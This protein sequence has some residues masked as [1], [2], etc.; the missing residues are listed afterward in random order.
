MADHVDDDPQPSTSRARNTIEEKRRMRNMRKSRK[1]SRRVDDVKVE[2]EEIAQKRLVLAKE[3]C[4]AEKKLRVAAEAEVRKFRGMAKTYFDRFCWEVEQRRAAMVTGSSHHP[5]I[6]GSGGVKYGF[7]EI[8]MNNLEDPV[9]DGQQKSLYVGRGSFAIVRVQ[10]YRG[11]KVAVKEYLPRCVKDDLLHEAAVLS[12]LCHPYLPLLIGV[13][14]SGQPLCLVM[15]FHGVDSFKT[16]I[17]GD[18][19]RQH[20]HICA[21]SGWLIL[22]GQLMEALRYLHDEAGYL[23]ND[24]KVDNILLTS[25]RMDGMLPCSSSNVCLSDEFPY[26][27]ILIDFGK[28]STIKERKYL[29]LTV[30]QQHMYKIKYTHIAGEVIEGVMPRSTKSDMYALGKVLQ[31]VKDERR[32]YNLTDD[33]QEELSAIIDNCILPDYKKRPE[34]GQCLSQIKELM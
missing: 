25:V 33:V 19:L 4:D 16:L 32:Y 22:T 24:I 23:H 5:K 1:R 34:A 6:T 12:Q 7:H 10:L 29:Q 8:S 27:V 18:E 28:A 21:G 2:E 26:Q 9:V 31:Q 3:E 14:S 15:Q 20:K 13:C 30:A 17:L 11:M